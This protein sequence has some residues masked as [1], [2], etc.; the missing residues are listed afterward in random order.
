MGNRLFSHKI[1]DYKFCITDHG[2]V[3]TVDLQ[4]RSCTRR[5]FD[6]DKIPCPHAMGV[7]RAQY[8]HRY[9]P[10]VYE[11]YSQYY[12]VE[13]YEMAYSGYITLVPPKES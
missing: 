4:T 8:E 13:K 1:V 2:D 7:V 12:S 10:E 3:A 9:G 6:L 11:H 5:I